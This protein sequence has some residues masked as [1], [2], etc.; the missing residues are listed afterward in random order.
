MAS[1]AGS[2]LVARPMLTDPN[3]RRAVVLLLQ[4]DGDGAFGLVV[5]RPAKAGK[6][7][8][9][10]F[11]GGPCES[12]GLFLLH[13]YEEWA[14]D[15]PEDEPQGVAPGIFLGDHTC[16]TRVQELLGEDVIRCRLFK[17]YAGWGPGQLEGELA[18]GAWA[19]VPANGTLLFETP[20]AEL[21]TLLLPP[22]IPEPSVN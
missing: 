17:S 9:P 3:F 10:V 4:H 16:L 11:L 6:L 5:N 20:A 19:V 12:E 13:G 18:H 1:F 2:F 8:L 21:W 22:S 7:P 15:E 14:D